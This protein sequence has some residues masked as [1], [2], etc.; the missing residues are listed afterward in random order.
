M[1]PQ[2]SLIIQFVTLATLVAGVVFGVLEVHRARVARADKAAMDV[3]NITVQQDVI[4]AIV[5][6]LDLPVDADAERIVASAELRRSTQLL[7]NLYEYWGM[8]VFY[9]I[10]PLRTLDL[11]VGGVVRGSWRRLHRYVEAERR[12]R[13][14][15]TLA[16]WFQWLA[17]RL[18]QYP[19]PE[20]ALGAHVAFSSW[21]P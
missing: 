16:E 21:K 19:Q 3:F 5:G 17:E 2:F 8:M 7:L 4:D 6:I 14:V 1:N 12:A 15:P 10:V 18:E 13:S 9:R 11:L 20:K